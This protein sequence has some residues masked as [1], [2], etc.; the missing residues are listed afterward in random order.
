M[1]RNGQ[2]WNNRIRFSSFGLDRTTPFIV[3]GYPC[4]TSPWSGIWL[5]TLSLE[6]LLL[7][8]DVV[9]ITEWNSGADFV[10][11]GMA[12]IFLDVTVIDSNGFA[13]LV[14]GWFF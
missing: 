8:F 6:S 5:W 11:K 7:P 14:F 13:Y 1:A 9:S 4:T 12:P 10:N 3:L 2:T